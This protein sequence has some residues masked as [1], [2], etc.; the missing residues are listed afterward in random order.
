M[1]LLVKG[2]K[3]WDHSFPAYKLNQKSSHPENMCDIF[4]EK[5]KDHGGTMNRASVYVEAAVHRVL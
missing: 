1:R 3:Y 5:A 4:F 2:L